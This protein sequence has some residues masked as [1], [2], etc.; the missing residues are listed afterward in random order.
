MA[1]DHLLDSVQPPCIQLLLQRWL[2]EQPLPDCNQGT[3]DVFYD[4]R[5]A[6]GY[7]ALHPQPDFRPKLPIVAFISEVLDEFAHDGIP[8]LTIFSRCL[9]SLGQ[10]PY[11][12]I[13]LPS[14]LV[15]R[16][17]S[18]LVQYRAN[19]IDEFSDDV[20]VEE[21]WRISRRLA[22]LRLDQALVR[23][24]PLLQRAQPAIQQGLMPVA[25][26]QDRQNLAA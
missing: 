5:V 8:T 18:H 15:A 9:Q 17:V 11:R 22:E 10:L 16:V 2:G 12:L 21:D 3:H 1:Q 26:D 23:H 24:Q 13:K 7:I 6:A 19:T 4:Q 25:F 20:V 14:K